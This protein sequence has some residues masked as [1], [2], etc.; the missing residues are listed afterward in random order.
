MPVAMPTCR[1]VELTPLAMPDRSTGTTPTAVEASGGLI[2]P[3]PTPATVR[4][5]IRWV[6]EE[7][8]WMPVSSSSPTP[9]IRKPGAISHFTGT[10]SVSRPAIAAAKNEAPERY[11]N[12]TPVSTAE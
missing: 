12:R 10:F 3:I 5:G 9:R 8:T 4:P 7:S 2:S 1:K 11:R 6:H